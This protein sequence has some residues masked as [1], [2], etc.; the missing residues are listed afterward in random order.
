MKSW[1]ARELMSEDH[2]PMKNGRFFPPTPRIVAST[3]VHY[4]TGTPGTD[5][6]T[7]TAG[8]MEVVSTKDYRV[9]NTEKPVV[10]LPS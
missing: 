2:Y 10:K 1:R 6:S 9:F 4:N 5:Y 3:T 8:I 7:Q